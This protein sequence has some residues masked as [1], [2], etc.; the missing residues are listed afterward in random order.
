MFEARQS[1]GRETGTWLDGVRHGRTPRVGRPGAGGVPPRIDLAGSDE[2][3]RL[4]QALIKGEFGGRTRRLLESGVGR[5]TRKL[6]EEATETGID[7]VKGRR[8]GVVRESADLIYHLVVLWASMGIKPR[9]VWLEMQRR[10][11]YLG[12]AEKWPKADADASPQ[13]AGINRNK[14]EGDA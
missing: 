13:G 7:A 4:F 6:V 9:R 5:R 11:E 1:P 2:I 3:D 12:L 14:D 8:G 10:R